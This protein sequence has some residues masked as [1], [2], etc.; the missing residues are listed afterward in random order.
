MWINAITLVSFTGA[1]L[2][3]LLRVIGKRIRACVALSSFSRHPQC[4]CPASC[5]FVSVAAGLVHFFPAHR[6]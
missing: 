1:T 6:S 5:R 2:M 3:S 4:S